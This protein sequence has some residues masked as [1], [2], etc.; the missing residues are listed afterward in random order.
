MN[1]SS[2]LIVKV[3]QIAVTGPRSSPTPADREEVK[4]A[5]STHVSQQG[6]LAEG[7][8]QAFGVHLPQP[9]HVEGPAVCRGRTSGVSAAPDPNRGMGTPAGQWGPHTLPLWEAAAG[10]GGVRRRPTRSFP[11]RIV[12][13]ENKSQLAEQVISRALETPHRSDRSPTERGLWLYPRTLTA[14][15]S[16][17]HQN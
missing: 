12:K 5:G 17:C 16:T 9:E 3:I 4:P 2:F 13:G 6:L 7:P 1:R 8:H 14:P 11:T 10:F 15:H